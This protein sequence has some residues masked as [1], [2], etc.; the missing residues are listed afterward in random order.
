[1]T[2]EEQR[3]NSKRNVDEQTKAAKGS[4]AAA[5]QAEYNIRAF[6]QSIFAMVEK[7]ITPIAQ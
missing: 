1:M 7:F 6:G 2:E 3:K 4:A 5:A